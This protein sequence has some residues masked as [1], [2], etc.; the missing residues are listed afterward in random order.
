MSYIYL[1][2]QVIFEWE[3]SQTPILFPSHE[4][5]IWG[6]SWVWLKNTLGTTKWREIISFQIFIL[7]EKKEWEKKNE[8]FHPTQFMQYAYSIPTTFHQSIQNNW[9]Y[10]L[11]ITFMLT[12]IIL[13]FIIRK[14][15]WLSSFCGLI[16]K[17]LIKTKQP[18]CHFL[19]NHSPKTIEYGQLGSSWKRICNEKKK[20]VKRVRGENGRKLGR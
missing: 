4:V 16:H 19:A 20:K 11:R 13:F 18:N 14:S 9:N 3:G 5:I 15:S 2:E 7:I 8:I 12:Q 10:Q 17:C 1:R 6:G